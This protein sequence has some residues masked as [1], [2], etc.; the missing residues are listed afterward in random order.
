MNWQHRVASRGPSTIHCG[1]RN[2]PWTF[3]WG[4]SA[5]YRNY[6]DPDPTI[7]QNNAE[8]DHVFW[9]R[10]LSRKGYGVRARQQNVTPTGSTIAPT[11]QAVINA[12]M[13]AQL[14]YSGAAGDIAK[15]GLREVPV[16]ESPPRPHRWCSRRLPR[17]RRHRLLSPPGTA[18]DR[19][20]AEPQVVR[21]V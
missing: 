8:V 1:K 10:T 2:T 18:A 4:A 12:M 15:A 20:R 3:Q 17:R 5:I 14:Y 11:T 21:L 16:P 13:T 9:T 7:D 6:D 19:C